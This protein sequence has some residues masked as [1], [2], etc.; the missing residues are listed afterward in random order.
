MKRLLASAVVTLAL[1]IGI[2]SAPFATVVTAATTT[3]TTR[4]CS[5]ATS[6]SIR[7][8]AS[9][10]G[11]LV[12]TVGMNV[13]L[14]V[15]GTT[16]S[17]GAWG[18]SSCAVPTSGSTWYQ[19][20]AV[21]STAV[22]G[23]I[24]A[25]AVQ[26]SVPTPVTATF[27]RPAAGTTVSQPSATGNVTWTETGIVTSR[28]ITEF[29]GPA[30]AGTCNSVTWTAVWTSTTAT[31]PFAISGFTLGRCYRYTIV[32]NGNPAKSASSGNL[33]ITSAT[34][35]KNLYDG[36]L[37]RYQDPDYTACTATSTMMMLNFTATKGTKGIGFRWGTTISYIV[38]ESILAWDRAHD[39]LVSTGRGS[40][41]NGWRNA[42][43][44]YGWN[45]YT[46]SAT[47]T[48]KVF[49]YSSYDAAVKAAVTAMA[50][51][52]KPVG[53]LAW[54]GGH[55][56]V[57]NGYQISGLN[58]ATSSNFTVQYVYIT[59]PLQK[60][61]L[62]NAQI[63]N[64]NFKAGSLTYRFRAYAYTDSPYDDPYTAGTVAAYQAWYG[65]WVIAAPVR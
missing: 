3:A 29:Y 30:V 19:V 10:S 2:S 54:A 59:D 43:N 27:T 22:S 4:V 5:T 8:T 50:K 47:M 18:P 26:L 52:N 38:Q 64:T 32:L 28:A 34:Y 17:G 65:K 36:A 57:L 16:T 1:T 49:A 62:R 48:Y 40:D 63:S 53:L 35:T 45:N 46:N 44:F 31:S 58:P 24:Y 23:Y 11:T 21:G 25:G 61:A 9:G 42:L 51:Y 20:F 7:S 12:K 56:Q 15:A 33:L 37:V 13:A 60:D 6:Y 41:P 14:T 39:T 55:A